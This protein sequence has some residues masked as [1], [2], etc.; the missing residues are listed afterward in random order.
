MWKRKL[1]SIKNKN[2]SR[3]ERQRLQSDIWGAYWSQCYIPL[4]FFLEELKQR[5]RCGGE[6]FVSLWEG[7]HHS[8]SSGQGFFH[9]LLKLSFP[10]SLTMTD[11]SMFTHINDFVRR[12][13]FISGW[14]RRKL[15]SCL[16]PTQSASKR[17]QHVCFFCLSW[18]IHTQTCP[19]CPISAITGHTDNRLNKNRLWSP[20][21]LHLWVQIWTQIIS[22]IK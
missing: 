2:M 5:F 16:F 21:T 4:S 14:R 13:R 11:S 18:R 9:A 1:N 17:P 3:V 6:C 22:L 20:D 19:F 8:G 15:S 12:A 10:V 7:L